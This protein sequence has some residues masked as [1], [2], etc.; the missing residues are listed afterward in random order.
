MSNNNKNYKHSGMPLGSRDYVCSSS[1]P[2][3]V[4]S[5]LNRARPYL[6]Q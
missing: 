1:T 6:P 5:S 2:L 4:A 3:T